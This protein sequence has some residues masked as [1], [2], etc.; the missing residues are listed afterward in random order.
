MHQL[1]YATCIRA[2]CN[3]HINMVIVASLSLSLFFLSFLFS[4]NSRTRCF[5]SNSSCTPSKADKDYGSPLHRRT[6]C[7]HRAPTNDG[8][9]DDDD[10]DVG[11]D[12]DNY[13]KLIIFV[14][15]LSY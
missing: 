7:R 4:T 14:G 10:D 15:L 9:D 11:G 2:F 6:H 13:M 3:R 12:D 8:G 5:R 1:W